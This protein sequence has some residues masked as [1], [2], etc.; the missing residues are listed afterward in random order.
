MKL[1]KSSNVRNR[2]AF[3]MLKFR[4]VFWLLILSFGIVGV[5]CSDKKTADN[6]I[7]QINYARVI[8]GSLTFSPDI[9][10]IAYATGG[11]GKQWVVVNRE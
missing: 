8:E 4:T 11:E 7:A 9:R 1:G 10:Q 3:N 2:I 6:L 5:S